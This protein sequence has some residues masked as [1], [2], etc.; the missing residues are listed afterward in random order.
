MEEQKAVE[1]PETSVET[2]E[3]PTLLGTEETAEETTLLSEDSVEEGSEVKEAEG[4]P[5]VPESYEIKAPEGMELDTALMEKVTPIFK[6]LGLTNE[7]VQKLA[8]VYSPYV[9][10]LVEAGTK[11]ALEFHNQQKDEWRK[12]SIAALGSKS[13]EELANTA[14]FI[15]TFSS[16]KEEAKAI[17]EMLDISGL[18][19]YLPF[20][21]MFSNAGKRLRQDSFAEPNKQ[22]TIDAERHPEKYLYASSSG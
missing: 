4:K 15:N 2:V 14:K 20:I 16:S 10:E 21:R 13:K 5:V 6:E 9:K 18:G 8:D 17:R 22:N 7:Q 1:T 3:T 12:E 19:N 11:E